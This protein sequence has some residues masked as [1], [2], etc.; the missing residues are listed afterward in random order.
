ME[1]N[2]LE[3]D[4]SIFTG[5][6]ILTDYY[7]KVV[8]L[9]SK[10][11]DPSVKIRTVILPSFE[12]E[13]VIGIREKENKYYAFKLFAK[14]HLWAEYQKGRDK[15]ILDNSPQ[16]EIEVQESQVEISP[17]VY[18][19]LDEC[20]HKMLQK[21][22]YKQPHGLGGTTYHF[23][24]FDMLAGRA[25]SPNPNSQTGYLVKLTEQL[26]ELTES[27]DSKTIEKTIQNTAKSLLNS[28]K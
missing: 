17:Q 15:T 25:W 7:S 12:P 24:T 13:Y 28:L 18:R 8:Q 26:G 11:Y 16:R 27:N 20:W 3:P 1:K 22:E 21:I 10:A 6:R 23:S 19:I 14:K 5:F 2:Q 9:F 4:L